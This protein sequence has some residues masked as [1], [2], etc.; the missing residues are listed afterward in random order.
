MADSVTAR[1]ARRPELGDLRQLASG[2]QVRLGDGSEDGVRVIDVRVAGGIDALVVADRGLD[3][4]P[5]WCGGFPLAWQSPTGIVHPSYFRDDVWLRSF[6]GGLLFTAGL[7][8]V[9]SAVLDGDEAHGLHGRL[10]NLPANSVTVETVEDERGLAVVVAG[11]V[12]ETSVYGVDL[13]LRRTLR[14][15]VGDPR[16][17]LT[18]EVENRGYQPAPVFLLYHVNLGHPVVAATSRLLAPPAEVVGWD[19][20]SRTAEAEYDRFVPPTAGFPV[21]VFEHR[22]KATDDDRVRIGIMNEADP[23]TGGIGVVIEYDRH[24]LP[25][26]WHWRMLAEGIYVTGFEPANCGLLGRVA[27]RAAGPLDVLPPGERR[28]FGVTI[29]AAVGANVSRLAGET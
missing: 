16:I 22:L 13:V 7:Q 18:D 6:H 8:N 10:S 3:I 12:R 2:R 24:R 9:G 23:G 26:L 17:E 27:E 20:V 1:P 14:F 15:A 5:A 28:S 25:R 21:Q 29:R 11:E 4:G 19:D